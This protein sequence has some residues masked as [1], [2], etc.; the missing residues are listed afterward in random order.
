M[1]TGA[2]VGPAIDI[3]GRSQYRSMIRDM[4]FGEHPRER[5]KEYGPRYLSNTELIAIL[6]RTGIKGENVL[7]LASRLLA[8]LNGLAGLGRCT[9][10][11]LAPSGD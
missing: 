8:K 3:D 7:S 5:L 11:E 4:P 10:A 1:D 2:K 9:F 6:L